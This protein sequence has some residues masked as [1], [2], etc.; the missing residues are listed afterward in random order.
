MAGLCAASWPHRV[1]PPLLAARA[2]I[3]RNFAPDH[4]RFLQAL[5]ADKD[6]EPIP[7]IR[8]FLGFVKTFFGWTTDDLYGSTGVRL[9]LLRWKWRCLV[10]VIRNP[11]KDLR[12]LSGR[13]RKSS[14]NHK[15]AKPAKF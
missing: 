8:G 14:L 2:Y 12:A 5:P 1:D 3:N 15:I 11:K 7:E 9:C 10:E 6:D 4:C 13:S